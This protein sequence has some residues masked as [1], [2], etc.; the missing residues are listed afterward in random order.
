VDHAR[1]SVDEDLNRLRFSATGTRLVPVVALVLG[2]PALVR[3]STR[4]RVRAR[5]GTKS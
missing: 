3:V 5:V 1:L 4:V 2:E